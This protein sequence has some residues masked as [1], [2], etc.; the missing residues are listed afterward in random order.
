MTDMTETGYKRVIGL[1]VTAGF[2]LGILAT[3]IEA[4]TASGQPSW[5]KDIKFM[6]KARGRYE[7]IDNDPQPGNFVRERNYYRYQLMLGAEFHPDDQVDVMVMAASS[8]NSGVQPAQVTHNV[9]LDDGFRDDPLYISQAQITYRPDIFHDM[10]ISISGGKVRNPYRSSWLL[11]DSD[12]APE[13]AYLMTAPEM[14]KSHR[15]SAVNGFWILEEEV[16]NAASLTG[17]NTGKDA[18]MT[19]NQLRASLDDVGPLDLDFWGS[20]YHYIRPSLVTNASAAIGYGNNSNDGNRLTSEFSIY[21]LGVMGRTTIGQHPAS[22][23]FEWAKNDRA[24]PNPANGMVEDRMVEAR[25]KIGVIEMKGDWMADVLWADLESDALPSFYSDADWGSGLGNTNFKG[26]RYSVG[27]GLTDASVLS[28]AYFK[29]KE[30][31][32]L[33]NDPDQ[34]LVQV[35]YTVMF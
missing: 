29:V 10:G 3:R 12:I 11:W 24:R 33:R 5:L 26:W 32:S 7:N 31:N 18:Y 21:N 17:F 23:T 14:M 34:R 19:G 20:Y 35:D 15:V 6:G 1:L 16:G 27:Y 2:L 30:S 22:L 13:G 9:N 4:K 28:V 25:G 8:G